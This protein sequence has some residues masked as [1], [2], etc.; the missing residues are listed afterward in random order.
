METKL[1]KRFPDMTID[2]VCNFAE[3]GKS[4]E[5][6]SKDG[7]MTSSLLFVV[8]EIM[9]SDSDILQRVRYCIVDLMD[10]V[11]CIE[12]HRTK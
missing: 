7:C 6:M 5:E 10:L 3:L 8:N 12:D 4:V 2:E 9:R 1:Q 11:Q